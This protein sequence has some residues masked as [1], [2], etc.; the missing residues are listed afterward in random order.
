M[1]RASFYTIGCK[2]N[3]YETESLKGV[4]HRN[5]YEIVTEG[6]RADVC[7]INTCTVTERGDADCRQVIRRAVRDKGCGG[8]VVVTGC[9]AQRDP[10]A[11]AALEGVDLIVGNREK[12]NL[13]TYVEAAMVEREAAC[14]VAVGRDPT[15]DDFLDLDPSFHGDLT[16]ATLKVQDGCD[17]HC[18][19]CI[20]PQV[21]GGSRSRPLSQIIERAQ[22]IAREGYKEIALTGV[23]TGSYHD[24]GASLIDLI[25]ALD[26]VEG[27]HRIRLNS[28]EPRSVTDDLIDCA[29][30]M[31]KVCHHFHIPLQSGDD[32]ILHRMG[33]RYDTRYYA[34]RVDRI[35]RSLPDAAIG[36]DVMVGFPGEDDEAFERTVRFIDELPLIYLHVFTY[37]SR[38]GTPSVRMGGR[39]GSQQ[40]VE[41]SAVLRELS[42]KKREA[43]LR[44]FIGERVEVLVEAK[45]SPTT[46]RL[47]GL[48]GNYI[49]VHVETADGRRQT[50]DRVEEDLV[51]R[52]VE[53]TL[54][55]TQNGFAV[56]ALRRVVV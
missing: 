39:V 7:V 54:L 4:F 9:Y 47:T 22:E 23:N 44:G 18:T 53:T 15:I 49:R 25:K 51:N 28:L 8:M 32:A 27:L 37:S 56:G 14:R 30:G 41:R 24:R 35:V 34:E 26:R 29:A 50:A 3:I 17:E 42:R 52:I 16:R 19:Y 43:F 12:A 36:A 38:E 20:I 48:T 46:G 21:R 40:K 33:R 45:R 31:E 13:L 5:G 2:L 1:K 55:E 10:E 11:L 6:E